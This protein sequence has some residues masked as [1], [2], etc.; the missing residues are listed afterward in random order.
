MTSI[1]C[2]YISD[3]QIGKWDLEDQTTIGG[4]CVT[5]ACRQTYI[6]THTNI[7]TGLQYSNQSMNE[8]NNFN[9]FPPP[10]SCTELGFHLSPMPNILTSLMKL[11]IRSYL[12]LYN[13]SFT[14][15]P[16]SNKNP[17]RAAVHCVRPSSNMRWYVVGRIKLPHTAGTSRS[18]NR[19][20]TSE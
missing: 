18:A 17:A 7:G 2:M 4:I 10:Q 14:Y 15:R 13:V 16:Q 5:C 20:T 11:V 6:Y 12:S 9:L 3:K 8:R 1:L 19:G